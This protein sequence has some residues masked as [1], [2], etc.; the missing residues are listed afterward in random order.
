MTQII[1]S[2]ARKKFN[3]N[4][5]N[6]NAL[7]P[8]PKKTISLAST[9]QYLDLI[10]Y[11]KEYL[12]KKGYPIKIKK[13]AFY[14]AHV[15][16]C[17][18]NAFDKNSDNLL[19]LSDAKFH[20]INNAIQLNKEIFIFNSQTLE[21]ITHEDLKKYQNQLQA[22][23]KKFLTSNTIGILISNKKG[24]KSSNIKKLKEKLKSLNKDTYIFESDNIDTNEFE[25][26]ENIPIFINTACF[27]LSRDHPKIINLQDII[28]FF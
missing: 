10:P 16:G 15:L 28:E 7:D 24:Q 12:E 11:V 23:K 19:L 4:N 8:I 3:I 9:I 5:I 27:G 13:G 25:N 26:Y 1:Y 17:N 18:T 14:D 2:E 22:K 20:A 6:L 21:K